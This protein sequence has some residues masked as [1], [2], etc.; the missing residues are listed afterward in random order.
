MVSIETEKFM[1][2][3][4]LFHQFQVLF[5]EL[6]GS[7]V[8]AFAGILIELVELFN[9]RSHKLK[10]RVSVRHCA[11]NIQVAPQ[12]FFKNLQMI[13]WNYIIMIYIIRY[14]NCEMPHIRVLKI[15]LSDG[16]LYYIS[17]CVINS[18]LVWMQW[19]LWGLCL[20]EVGNLKIGWILSFSVILGP[21]KPEVYFWRHTLPKAYMLRIGWFHGFWQH[22]FL[23]T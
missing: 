9:K 21:L 22:N 1:V 10:M 15:F 12:W 5:V 3:K 6:F 8:L 14:E 4:M 13:Y 2:E 23:V 16:I 11:I 7:S 17:I 19:N 18:F 20:E